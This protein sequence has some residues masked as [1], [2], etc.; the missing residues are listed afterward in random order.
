MKSLSSWIPRRL[1]K[2]KTSNR[3]NLT[4]RRFKLRSRNNM[5]E[6]TLIGLGG[7]LIMRRN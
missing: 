5:K 3:C 1:E 2:A 4:K 7:R 6:R